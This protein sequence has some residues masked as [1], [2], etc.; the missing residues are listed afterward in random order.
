M[1]SGVIRRVAPGRSPSGTLCPVRADPLEHFRRWYAEAG[2]DVPE[3]LALATASADGAPS[4]RMVL[5]KQADEAG[6]V[7]FSNYESRK[8]RELAENPVAALLFH[9]A[10][11]QVRIEGRVERV[12]AEE[13]DAYWATRPLRSRAAA[14]AS[15]QSEVL[16]SR[17]ELE[18]RVAEAEA[19]DPP[20]PA[21]WGGYWLTPAVWEF[22]QHGDDR[23]HDRLRYRRDGAG[24]ITEALFP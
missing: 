10:G 7:F 3:A 5:L 21:H 23:L 20:R 15:R 19:A 11:R 18:R 22:W 14:F 6:F 24:W 4:V 13:S 16:E 17:D 1:T 9:W 8:G 12:P 2:V